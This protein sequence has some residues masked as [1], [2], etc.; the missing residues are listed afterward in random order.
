MKSRIDEIS[1]IKGIGILAVVCIHLLSI[2]GLKQYCGIG[3]KIEMSLCAPLMIMFFI[4]AG[5]L[6]SDRKTSAKDYLVG[7]L[8]R[9][10]VP[11][12]V[13][14]VVLLIAYAIIY[15]IIEE[16]SIGWYIDGAI[17]ILLQFQSFHWLDTS[18]SGLHPMF[19]GAVV[20][21]FLF[22]MA[23]AEVI[24]VPIRYRLKDKKTG[25]KLLLAAAFLLVGAILYI[26]DI[27]GLN[28]KPFSTV[29]LAF[30]LPNIPGEVG[31]MLLGDYL[32]K[33]DFLDFDAYS[34]KRKI[35]GFAISLALIIIFIAT[36]NYSY[37]FPFGGWGAFGALS[38]ATGTLYGLALITFLGIICNLI[39]NAE[40]VRKT[41]AYLGDISMSILVIH[42][43]LAYLI[44]YIIGFWQE[45]MLGPVETES[46][47]A[48][49]GYFLIMFA[50][51]LVVCNLF[52]Y[53][54]G[55][56]LKRIHK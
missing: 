52:P 32:S 3:I 29:L 33:L 51:I 25:L 34:I 22:Q 20:G 44:A 30:V 11:Y 53:A 31:L 41:L 46:A 50:V 19:Y 39:K 1:M 17:G 37:R 10:F 15:L 14:A 21:W 49:L 38:Y 6:S 47:G 18:I 43:F 9:I 7:R 26:P 27:Q 35:A 5:Y 48:A 8:N 24:F 56:A 23:I 4:L 45:P 36:D 42:Y 12:Y 40:P 13:M 54:L 2:S 28:D 55:R 16:K